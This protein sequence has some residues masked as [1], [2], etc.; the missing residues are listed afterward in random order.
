MQTG[1]NPRLLLDFFLT[2]ARFEYA[3]KKTGY[4]VHKPENI[5]HSPTAEPDWDR[6]TASLRDKFDASKNEELKRAFRYFLE[7][8]PNKQVIFNGDLGWETPMRGCS[9]EMEFV[10]RMVRVVRNNLF[11]GGKHNIEVHESTER[12][13]HFLSSSLVILNEC[14]ALDP[15]LRE[16]YNEAVV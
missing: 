7:S 14:L 15:D 9:S 8:P 10:L 13:E 11:H 12:T 3:L 6:F 1:A 16:A 5:E 2:F 4:F